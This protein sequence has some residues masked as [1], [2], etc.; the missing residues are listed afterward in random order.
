MV[1]VANYQ[2]NRVIVWSEGNVIPIRNISG[3]LSSPWSLFVTTIGDVYVDNG[4]SN[5]RVDKWTL[6]ATTSVPAM[7]VNSYCSGLFIDINDTLYCSILQYHQVVK[8][9]LNSNS[10]SAVVA[11]GNGNVNTGGSSQNLDQPNGIFVDINF[12]LYVADS[13]NGRIQLFLPGQTSGST[14]S[15]GSI[16]LNYPTGVAL[17]AD[18]NLFIVDY[19]NDCIIGSGPNGFQCIAGCSGSYGSAPD[20]LHD[21]LNLAFDSYGNIF[22]TDSNRIQKFILATNSCGKYESN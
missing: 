4:D 10:N 1:Y 16:T 7:N 17:D 13:N 3:G 22:V 20:Q 9:S 5:G 21:P 12:D 11:A 14:V 18:S 19:G 2:Y 15:T 8:Q 6:N